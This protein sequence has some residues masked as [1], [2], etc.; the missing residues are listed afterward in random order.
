MFRGVD[1]YTVSRLLG[2]SAI[3]TTMIY[4]KSN[5]DLLKTAVTMLEGM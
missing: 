2:H 3:R 4:A 5:T 1:I